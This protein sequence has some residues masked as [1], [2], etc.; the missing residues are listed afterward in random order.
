MREVATGKA[1]ASGVAIPTQEGSDGSADPLTREIGF[2]DASEYS[3][4]SGPFVTVR[5][6][7]STNQPR[8]MPGIGEGANC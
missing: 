7:A 4:G 5:A 3:L 6:G 1:A 2:L 8:N